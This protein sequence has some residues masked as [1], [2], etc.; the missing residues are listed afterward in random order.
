MIRDFAIFH[1]EFFF[2]KKFR[3]QKFV[4]SGFAFFSFRE[5][6]PHKMPLPVHHPEKNISNKKP[7]RK[8]SRTNQFP[9][10]H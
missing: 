10:S 3:L 1:T 2:F 7:A 5:K 6:I 9:I 4:Q 8:N